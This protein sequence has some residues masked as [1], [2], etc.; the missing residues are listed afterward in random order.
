MV[1]VNKDVVF[2][3]I[4]LISGINDALSRLLALV[5]SLKDCRVD[6]LTLDLGEECS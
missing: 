4:D 1:P 3:E 6:D 2:I 5:Q